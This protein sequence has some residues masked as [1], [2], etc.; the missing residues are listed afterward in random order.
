MRFT[1]YMQKEKFVVCASCTITIKMCNSNNNNNNN[2]ECSCVVVITVCK[3]PI[4]FVV[5]VCCVQCA[6]CFVWLGQGNYCMCFHDP[7][8]E[9]STAA[10]KTERNVQ[11]FIAYLAETSCVHCCTIRNQM[12]NFGE[13]FP[14]LCCYTHY[15]VV[16][17][18]FSNSSLW[19]WSKFSCLTSFA[20]LNFMETVHCVE[21]CKSFIEL[22]SSDDFINWRGRETAK[23]ITV[24]M[25]YSLKKIHHIVDRLLSLS[26]RW[27]WVN[28]SS[29]PIFASIRIICFIHVSQEFIRIEIQS[30]GSRY[31]DGRSDLLPIDP[32]KCCRL[33]LFGIESPKIQYNES[34]R[35]LYFP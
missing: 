7:W 19:S 21:Q 30:I 27:L 14:A 12:H 28:G 15:V 32:P 24:L 8:A 23:T 20:Y 11:R 6:M 10:W 4:V 33:N 17:I 18:S 26:Y 35:A 1:F 9:E 13:F 34:S 3:N 25:N 5:A 22:S 29:R 2:N 16:G 31:R